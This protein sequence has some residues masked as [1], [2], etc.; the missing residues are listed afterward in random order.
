MQ[1]R[2]KKMNN[3][4]SKRTNLAAEIEEAVKTCIAAHGS[5]SYFNHSVCVSARMWKVLAN[6]RKEDILRS[7]G[8]AWNPFDVECYRIQNCRKSN[9]I[10]IIIVSLLFVVV[11]SFERQAPSFSLLILHGNFLV[12]RIQTHIVEKKAT[13]FFS[14]RFFIS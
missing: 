12:G 8:I 10:I 4:N 14:L 11:C 6:K 2:K 13:Y 5:C 3:S 1:K 7:N 9:Q